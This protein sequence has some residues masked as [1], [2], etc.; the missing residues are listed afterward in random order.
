MRLLFIGKKD[1]Q[2]LTEI[3]SKLLKSKGR[4]KTPEEIEAEIEAIKQVR[5]KEIE[6]NTN[7]K[8]AELEL[9][10]QRLNRIRRFRE[11]Y[12]KAYENALPEAMKKRAEA[13]LSGVG[14]K[15]RGSRTIGL[16][17]KASKYYQVPKFSGMGSS[18]L[19]TGVITASRQI[20][21]QRDKEE[22]QK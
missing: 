10:N 13:E 7:K 22:F 19:P 12:N 1:D 5:L 9:E 18:A 17:Q 6:I 21:S 20:R 3:E 15:G 16:L 2:N 8:L 4:Q 14:Q 11:E